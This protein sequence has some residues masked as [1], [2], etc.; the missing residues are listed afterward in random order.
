MNVEDNEPVKQYTHKEYMYVNAGGV[1]SGPNDFIIELET[2]M[3]DGIGREMS[4]LM[5][6]KMAKHLNIM[7]ADALAAYEEH[8]TEIPIDTITGEE[9]LNKVQNSNGEE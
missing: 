6:P 8:V 9:Y 2:N 7:L 1:L 4:L 3:P 5:T